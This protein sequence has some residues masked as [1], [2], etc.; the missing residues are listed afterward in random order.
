LTLVTGSATHHFEPVG[1]SAVGHG[2]WYWTGT[3]LIRHDPFAA[4]TAPIFGIDRHIISSGITNEPSHYFSPQ[5]RRPPCRGLAGCGVDD[6][7]RPP[8]PGHRVG[9]DRLGDRH[10]LRRWRLRQ[11]PRLHLVDADRLRLRRRPPG[12]RRTYLPQAGSSS[13][14]AG[15]GSAAALHQ[16]ALRER[17][18]GQTVWADS[19]GSGAF[20]EGDKG[21]SHIIFCGPVEQE[22]STPTETPTETPTDTPTATPTDTPTATPTDEVQPTETPTETPTDTPTVCPDCSP[23]GHSGGGDQPTPTPTTQVEGISGTP[24]AVTPPPTDTLA[25][26]TVPSNDGWRMALAAL[27]GVIAL[28]LIVPK[29]KRATAKRR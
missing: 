2:H 28:T 23:G 22:T 25:S 26:T 10:R 21:I 16:H 18:A 19:N 27:A 13:S 4:R 14:Q 9:R 24:P 7:R 17:E 15:S 5:G 8:G 3:G 11:Q 6:R 1:F 12:P 20:D 29:P